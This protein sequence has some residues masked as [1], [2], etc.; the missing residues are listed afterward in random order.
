MDEENKIHEDIQSLK[1][2]PDGIVLDPQPSDNPN[3]PLNWAP[4]RK[5]LTLS[6]WTAACFI[7][8]VTVVTNMQGSYL[9]APLYHKTATEISLSISLALIGLIVGAI[10]IV[11]LSRRYGACFCL[12]WSAIGL[13]LTSVWSAL[14][15][16]SADYVPFLLSRLVAGLCA[17][18]PLILGSEVVL[19]MFFLHQRG[20]SLHILHIPFL[21]GVALGPTIGGYI[22]SQVSWTIS[23]WYTLPLNGVLAAVILTFL[24]DTVL[25]MEGSQTQASVWQRR[26]KTYARGKALSRGA[27]WTECSF[28]LLDILLVGFSP[29]SVIIGLFLMI[30]FG[31]ATMAIVLSVV[32]LEMP[33]DEGGYA[34]SKTAEASFTLIQTI[35]VLLAEVYGHF[36]SDRLPLFLLRQRS[37]STPSPAWHPEDRLH[38]LWLPVIILPIGLG[39]FGASLQYHLHWA[40]LAF[41]YLFISFGAMSIFPVAMT[42]L[43][44]CFP[45]Q[46]SEVAAAMGFWRLVLGLLTTVFITQWRESVGPGWV[47]GTAALLTIPAF[48]GVIGLMGFGKW[49]RGFSLG[50]KARE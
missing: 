8:Q 40:V 20:K 16:S 32:F 6:I 10:I 11:P 28:I 7:S 42:Y 25:D 9:Q 29:V 47:F 31:F 3:D 45:G 19:Q 26:W 27:S 50:R 35:G 39:L 12:F 46:I 24:E 33:R 49:V 15:T 4:S 21:L 43:C 36:I 18:V 48:G 14:M 13:L 34:M 22:N 37:K 44:E 17:G 38:C 2:T 5:A 1:T 23:F 41:G 30:D